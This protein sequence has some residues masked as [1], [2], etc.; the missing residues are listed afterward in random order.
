MSY[1][2][3]SELTCA[4]TRK[5]TTSKIGQKKYIPTDPFIILESP[6]QEIGEFSVVRERYATDFKAQKL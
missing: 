4:H 2:R 3:A 5:V 1:S 6:D